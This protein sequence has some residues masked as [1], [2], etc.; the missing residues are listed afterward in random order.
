M[1]L[2]PI[3]AAWIAT[4]LSF[5]MIATVPV[6][7]AAFCGERVSSRM[8]G[9]T[10]RCPNTGLK[11]QGWTADDPIE[12]DDDAYEPVTCVA[13]TRVHVVNPKTGKVLGEDNE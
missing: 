10:F 13:C 3:K 11:V 7:A 5:C 6:L 9:F 1:R 2:I 8:T 4:E 12:L